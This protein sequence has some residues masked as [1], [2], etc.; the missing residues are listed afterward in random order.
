MVRGAA[1][2]R[3]GSRPTATKEDREGS[4]C[5][6]VLAEMS[7]GG[8]ARGALG[9]LQG[10]GKDEGG[11]RLR[12]GTAAPEAVPIY[13]HHKTPRAGACAREGGSS[14]ANGQRGDAV[15]KAQALLQ[16]P[17]HDPTPSQATPPAPG[18]HLL[19]NTIKGGPSPL[20]QP[21]PPLPRHVLWTLID[22]QGSEDAPTC[23]P[24]LT[25]QTWG[26]CQGEKQPPVPQNQTQR[27]PGP[28]EPVPWG[29]HKVK[30]PGQPRLWASVTNG[31]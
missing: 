20:R 27:G 8:H 3:G 29:S 31:L 10:L 16:P 12:G 6:R 13:R 5:I 19:K 22:S 14:R 25:L 4:G 7:R 24:S 1:G 30:V 15:F 2:R 18:P 17:G 9:G 23:L 11:P 28:P 21:P 26:F